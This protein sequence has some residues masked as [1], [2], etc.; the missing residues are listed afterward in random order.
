MLGAQVWADGYIQAGNTTA[1]QLAVQQYGI[2][3]VY[4]TVVSTFYNY[5]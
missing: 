1:M 4:I 2:I 5:A 3:S